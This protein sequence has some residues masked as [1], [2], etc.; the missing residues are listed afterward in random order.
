VYDS[1]EDEEKGKQ[2]AVER[3][4]AE[5]T[6]IAD[7]QEQEEASI[8]LETAEAESPISAP[9]QISTCCLLADVAIHSLTSSETELNGRQGVCV[10]VCCTSMCV[11]VQHIRSGL[12]TS[13][14]KRW[15]V[16][17]PEGRQI[18]VAPEN[19]TLIC[20]NAACRVNLLQPLLK[21]SKCKVAL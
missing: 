9:S 4:E 2:E 14:P 1:S 18:W 16:Q 11:N 13:M 6:S 3:K 12:M 5:E 20:S 19:L 17:L 10:D 15:L 7:S 8:S 21:C